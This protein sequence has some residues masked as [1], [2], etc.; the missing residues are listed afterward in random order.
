VFIETEADKERFGIVTRLR[1]SG[2]AVDP[3]ASDTFGRLLRSYHDQYSPK[4]RR[5][6]RI[7]EVDRKPGDTRPAFL[8][9]FVVIAVVAISNAVMLRKLLRAR[10]MARGR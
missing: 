5:S 1:V 9:A 8:I 3:I 7:I 2:R 4:R 10:N 6:I